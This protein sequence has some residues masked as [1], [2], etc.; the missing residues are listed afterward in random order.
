MNRKYE[1]ITVIL[2]LIIIVGALIF[3]GRQGNLKSKTWFFNFS[4]FSSNKNEETIS[5]FIGTEDI[6]KFDLDISNTD[7]EIISTS[8]SNVK[9]ETTHYAED[10]YTIKQ[11]GDNISIKKDE[12]HSIFNFNN[13]TG[14]V[15][16][17]VPKELI[18]EYY[19]DIS[20]GRITIS[21]IYAKNIE[22]ETSNGDIKI[23]NLN[24]NN[25]IDLE[26]SNGRINVNNLIAE[27]IEL[28]TS[29]ASVTLEKVNGDYI[30]VETSNGTI[31]VNN[32]KGKEVE[33]DTS[34]AQIS[35]YECYGN[36]VILDTSNGNITLENLEDKEFVIDKL[37]VSTSNAKENIN[38]KY[39]SKK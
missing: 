22:I 34:N 12:N 15:K 18:A 2:V 3:A 27:D 32:C 30:I 35:A 7:L 21:D 25:N 29:N 14:N 16:I 23:D 13:K 36:E 26:T 39:N 6:L 19:G 1:I 38:A 9:I 24:V 20:N 5:E 37:R 10:K 31:N 28:D 11:K 8:E 4:S 17:F 33:L